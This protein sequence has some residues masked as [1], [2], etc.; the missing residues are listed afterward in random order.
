MCEGRV[1]STRLLS[2]MQ[3]TQ[4]L[5]TTWNWVQRVG[6]RIRIVNWGSSAAVSRG[7]G[8]RDAYV[9][10]GLRTLVAVVGD[11]VCEP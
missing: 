4:K 5:L 6:T 1:G 11:I 3:T 9:I 8:D 2:R 7:Q 10:Q